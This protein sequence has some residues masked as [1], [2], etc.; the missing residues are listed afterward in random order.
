MAQVQVTQQ[1]LVY[2]QPPVYTQPPGI[3]VMTAD[4]NTVLTHLQGVYVEQVRRIQEVLG[5]E[6]ANEYA[7]FQLDPST[8]QKVGHEI[9]H[10]KERSRDCCTRNCLGPC[11]SV[12]ADLYIVN[13]ELNP[14]ATYTKTTG[15]TWCACC[16]AR[17]S[18]TTNG[19]Q[20]M[21][22]DV[23]SP[24][25]CPGCTPLA[26]SVANHKYSADASCCGMMPCNAYY[27]GVTD[28]RNG[29]PAGSLVKLP[30]TCGDLLYK[31]N[32]VS[33]PPR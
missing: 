12:T 29:A 26:F 30:Q 27:F 8:G 23:E 2:M 24:N 20:Q 13:N 9:M 1:P 28:T 15:I 25:A 22:H 18:L 10:A 16:K 32:K 19:P 14:M 33:I 5:F 21:V 11:R 3:Q 6:M 4:A 7:I 17:A 31:T